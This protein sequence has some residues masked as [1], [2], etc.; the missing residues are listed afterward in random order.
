MDFIL[1]LMRIWWWALSKGVTGVDFLF[2]S[3]SA[4]L[5]I[6][7]QGSRKKAERVVRSFPGIWGRSE[8]C[9][10]ALRRQRWGDRIRN[11]IFEGKLNDIVMGCIGGIRESEEQRRTSRVLY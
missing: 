11:G 6:Y 2:R 8:S 9:S 1:S 5:Q 10:V 3:L 4:K 7:I